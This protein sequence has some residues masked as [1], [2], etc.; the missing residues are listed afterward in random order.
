MK[1]ILFLTALPFLLS[2]TNLTYAQSGCQ[3]DFYG[4]PLTGCEGITVT[5]YDQSQGASQWEWTFD[6]G[7]PASASGEGPHQVVYNSAG[8]YTVKLEIQCKSGSDTETKTKYIQI[9]DCTCSPDFSANKTNVCKNQS[10]TFTDNS[11]GATSWVWTFEGGTPSVMQGQGP[12]NITYNQT[13]SFDVSLEI[14][15]PH[16][17]TRTETKTDYIQVVN[18]PCDAKFSADQTHI[19]TGDSVT[20]TDNSLGAQSWQW[21]FEGGTPSGAQTQGPHSV[22]YTQDGTYD[23]SLQITCA[24]G[25][26]L[27]VKDNLILVETL[28]LYD[29]GDAP[30]GVI[31]YPSAGTAGQFPTCKDSGPA[32][33]IQ[34]DSSGTFLGNLIDYETEGN[35]GSCSASGP[36]PYDQDEQC[37]QHDSGLWEPDIYTIQGEEGSEEVVFLCDGFTGDNLGTADGTASWGGGKDINLFYHT[38]NPE[39]AYINVLFDWNQDGDWNDELWSEDVSKTIY[40]HTVVNFPVPVGSGHISALDPPDFTI[41][42]NAGFVWARFTITEEPVELPWQGTGEFEAGESE[43]HLLKIG[44]NGLFQYRIDPTLKPDPPTI[45]GPDNKNFTAGIIIF[46]KLSV[47]VHYVE[48][49]IV[50]KPETQDNLTRVLEKYNGI[51][52]NDGTI[53]DLPKQYKNLAPEISET[54]GW[55]RIHIER[56]TTAVDS[57]MLI[58]RAT[59]LGYRGMHVFNSYEMLSTF[60]AFISEKS[61]QEHICLNG[62][63]QP[64]CCPRSSAEDYPRG[65]G[66]WNAYNTGWFREFNLTQAWY[67]A[68]VFE[69]F[70]PHI[71]LAALDRGFYLNDDFPDIRGYDFIDSDSDVYEDEEAWHGTNVLSVAAAR[72]NNRFGVTG[73]SGLAAIPVAFRVATDSDIALAINTGVS[74][75]INVINISRGRV[76]PVSTHPENLRE[77]INA[78]SD[79]G[80]ILVASAGN[81]N[82]DIGNPSIHQIPAEAGTPGKDPITVGGLR[83]WDKT[84]FLLSNYGS[85]VDIYAPA[86]QF[87]VTPEPGSSSNYSIFNGT[88]CASPYIAGVAALMKALDM[89]LTTDDIRQILRTTATPST[90][91]SVTPGYIDALAAVKYVCQDMILPPDC[92]EPSSRIHSVHIDPGE[93]CGNLSSEDTEDTYWF[94]L[95]DFWHVSVDDSAISHCDD[96]A[97]RLR[98]PYYSTPVYLPRRHVMRPGIYYIDLTHDGDSFGL[99]WLSFQLDSLATIPPDRFEDNDYIFEDAPLYIRNEDIGET[100]VIDDLTFHDTGDP[101]VDYFEIHIPDL[102]SGLYDEQIT[103]Y[104]EP[105]AYGD[106]TAGYYIQF[107][108][109]TGEV[110]LEYTSSL[111]FDN[112][113]SQWPEGVIRF[114]VQDGNLGRNY[115]RMLIGYDQW[116]RTAGLPQEM[117][118]MEVPDWLEAM[119]AMPLEIPPAAAP[120]I[121]LPFTFPSDPEMLDSIAAGASPNTIPAEMLILKWYNSRDLGINFSSPGMNFALI[122][123]GGQI[124]AEDFA[125]DLLLPKNAD[126]SSKVTT[127]IEY[128]DLPRGIYGIQVEGNVYPVQYTITFDSLF[129]PTTSVQ[130]NS[131][132]EG[133]LLYSISQNYPNPF[134]ATTCI[135]YDLK[136]Q[137]HIKITITNITGQIVDEL[138]NTYKQEGQYTVQWDGTDINGKNAPSG[139]YICRIQA[140]DYSDMKK[141]LLLK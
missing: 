25:S 75:G 6:G 140:G 28:P 56:D 84:R 23:V 116:I 96:Y 120:D 115:Y 85:S 131:Q 62:I 71:L 103:I 49:D 114:S 7:K 5:F 30:E 107:F 72:L 73:T 44:E 136:K 50:F 111:T 27:K 55:Y 99:Y 37:D 129:I 106:A 20:F 81:D 21:T 9:Y 12:H 139:I 36:H 122:G 8:Y 125:Y 137:G 124:I 87:I 58:K 138:V 110:I 93:L 102:P 108:D 112:L 15:C 130:S 98:I 70:T 123:D 104:F 26:D 95:N 47:P 118:L 40:E 11:E 78:A 31:A 119:A 53:P 45:P 41:G 2:W 127:R 80:V 117:A 77:A 24:S 18:C 68:D 66:Y 32:G 90:D 17:G 16:V 97:A 46:P 76:T 65:D 135:E 22:L 67:L 29:F 69:I 52:L 57:V 92:Q 39:G 128:K 105:G 109:Q 132:P 64:H 14:Y 94:H 74:Y 1:K 35:E 3:A 4:D 88:S 59:A 141:I 83:I 79:A 48:Q 10:V 91:P 34:H 43:D 82:T 60:D 19:Y 134:N 113:R 42:P 121:P 101:D 51:I 61:R 133:V 33:Y 54:T 89:S 100:K 13:G 63:A 38:D 126:D 86:D